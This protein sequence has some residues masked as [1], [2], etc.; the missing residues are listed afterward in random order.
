MIER[1]LL[2]LAEWALF[3]IILL[4]CGI[5]LIGVAGISAASWLWERVHGRD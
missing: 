3:S 4:F 5:W 2:T 1:L